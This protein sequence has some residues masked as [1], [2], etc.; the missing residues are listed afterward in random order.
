[1]GE[2]ETNPLEQHWLGAERLRSVAERLQDHAA[3]LEES[4]LPHMADKIY[5]FAEEIGD[6]EKIV[7]KACEKMASAAVQNAAQNSVTILAATLAGVEIG[8]K[9]GGE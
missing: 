9:E 2:P 8:E 1:M 3:S 7:S 6:A 4:G 5:R